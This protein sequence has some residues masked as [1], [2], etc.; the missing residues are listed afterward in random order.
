LFHR[1]HAQRWLGHRGGVAL[2]NVPGQGA[3]KEYFH[4]FLPKVSG[5]AGQ[6]HL[7][8]QKEMQLK[9]RSKASKAVNVVPPS[10]P[11]IEYHWGRRSEF[12]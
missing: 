11:S 1:Y 12:R 6:G 5:R 2:P 8:Q 3:A 9:H 4:S 10:L 7:S